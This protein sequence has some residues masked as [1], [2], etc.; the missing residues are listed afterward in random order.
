MKPV[1][2]F[3]A[4]SPLARRA[5]PSPRGEGASGFPGVADAPQSATTIAVRKFGP[6]ERALVDALDEPALVVDGT[7]IGIANTA[8]RNL[9]GAAI[10][11]RD[12][13]LAIRHPQALDLVAFCRE[14]AAN[15][16]YAG[17]AGVSFSTALPEP[18][19]VR[20]EAY[21]LEDAVTHVLRNADR[22]RPDGTPSVFVVAASGKLEPRYI[23]NGL[24]AFWS[25]R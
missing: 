19:P 17:I 3:G 18:L 13:R 10:E 20:A 4:L 8:A 6:A 7:I 12:I 5:A 21:A 14:I 15:A 9:L 1:Q 11:G 25:P 23:V 2:P 16:H 22:Y 24:A